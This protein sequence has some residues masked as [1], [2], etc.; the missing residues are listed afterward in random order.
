MRKIA[1]LVGL[2][3]AA[4]GAA[5]WAARSAGARQARE[6]MSHGAAPGRLGSWMNSLMNGPG[7]RAFAQVLDVR[8]EDELLD[9][10]CG[11]GEFLV[12]H[13]AGARRVSG[14]DLA[15]A[16]VALARERLAD[17]I[18]AGTAEIVVA[19]AARLPWPDA[20]FTAVTCIDAFPFF[21]DP[22]AVL[23]EFFRVLRP[24]G[25]AVVT[26]GAEQLP[27]GVESRSARGIAGTYTAISEATARNMVESAGFDPVTVSWVPVAGEHRLIGAVLRDVAGGDMADIV[28]GRKPVDTASD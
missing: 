5:L 24:G 18:E 9:V 4:A 26:F 23:A 27:E 7:Y 12:T 14:V 22:Q 15:P 8:Q 2:A 3:A 11:W 17:R 6:A 13:A 1:A 20:S 25:R 28:I 10:A 21:P 16:K 19:D